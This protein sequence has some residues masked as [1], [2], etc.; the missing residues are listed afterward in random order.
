[1]DWKKKKI[2]VLG[3]SITFGADANP[4]EDGFVGQLAKQS[5]A[6]VVNLGI[7][8]TRIARKRVPSEVAM[9]DQD[10]CGRFLEIP[11]DTEVI[12]VFG[13]TNDYGHGDA[14]LGDAGDHT[15]DTFRGA[16]AYLPVS[17]THLTLPTKA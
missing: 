7:C 9:F 1:M 4:P 16:C 10:F 6:R 13:G 17:Y 2:A 11:R 15:P 8:G 5:R 14:P 3:D 12:L